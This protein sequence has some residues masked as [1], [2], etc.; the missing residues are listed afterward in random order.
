MQK[1]IKDS[2]V[3]KIWL[4]TTILLILV[5]FLTYT[6]I[7]FFVPKT[8]SYQLKEGVREKS[9]DLIKELS[10]VKKDECSELL[11]DFMKKYDV[12]V[13]LV[14]QEGVIDMPEEVL[15]YIRTGRD[16]EGLET[17]IVESEY[18]ESEADSG[19]FDEYESESEE[20]SEEISEEA[21]ELETNTAED[22]PYMIEHQVQF[23]DES[24]I[25]LMTITGQQ[26]SVN[27]AVEALGKLL[28]WLLVSIVFVSGL[29]A[30]VYAS[31]ITKPIV[32]IS[33]TAE[34]MAELDF[35]VRCSET[36]TD[37]IGVLAESLNDMSSKLGNTLQELQKANES[38]LND[39][40]KERKLERQRMEFFSA[41]SHELKT[42][43]TILKG[44]LEGMIRKIGIY[45]DRDKYLAR[46]YDTVENM[47][48][49]AAEIL[50]ISRMESAEVHLQHEPF[51][52]KQLAE[53][54]LKQQA[55]LYLEKHI[56]VEK[57]DL[58]ERLYIGERKLFQ[59]VVSNLIGNAIQY[60]PKK[61]VIRLETGENDKGVF[62]CV[63]NTGVHIPEEMIESLFHAFNR[64]E[65]SRNRNTGGSGL[66]LYLV[67]RILNLYEGEC[68]MENT[69]EGIQVKV[70]LPKLHKNSK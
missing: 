30:M 34:W 32:R 56:K 44:Q 14:N 68:T 13:T 46:C 59:K 4:I 26:R 27:Q 12:D 39:I 7:V 33:K 11:I 52:F 66:G 31:Y 70:I 65:K 6:F 9:G 35:K 17:D 5:S 16:D 64:M 3:V 69:T 45:Q 21:S 22:S 43:I 55:P 38:L 60:S 1:K 42:P 67:R 25:Y 54:C 28:P 53:E 37:E 23:A 61:S 41:V 62:F 51:D 29:S 49:L 24:E 10:S 47:E 63:E 40:E 2:L 20:I 48:G 8:Y 18:Y 57:E 58:K 36:R 15:A 19:F 50:M